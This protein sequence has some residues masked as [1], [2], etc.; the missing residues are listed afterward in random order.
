MWRRHTNDLIYAITVVSICLMATIYAAVTND[1]SDNIW[2]VYG[3]A[4]AFAAGR[5]GAAIAS[6]MRTERFDDTV[7]K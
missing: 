3:S 1:K 4:I 2:I 6:S 5:S 7:P